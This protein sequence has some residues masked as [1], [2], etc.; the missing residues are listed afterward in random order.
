MPINAIT[1]EGNFLFDRT[2]KND[3]LNALIQANIQNDEIGDIWITGDKGAQAICTPE[4]S[5][6]LHN[7]Q[8]FIRDVQITFKELALNDLRPPF[9]RNPKRLST[10]EASKRLDAIASAGFGLSRSKVISNIKEG[11]L[12]LNWEPIK[13]TSRLLEIGDSVQFEGKGSIKIIN[14][15]LTKRDR[16]RVEILRE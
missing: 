9:Q 3:F 14:I 8:G 12:R 1:I 5:D 7:Q 6:D 2:E 10:V 15:E 16:W 11:R 4:A 13:N